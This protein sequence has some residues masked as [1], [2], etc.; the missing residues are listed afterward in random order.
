MTE[1]DQKS[2][3]STF[4]SAKSIFITG[5]TGFIGKQIIEKLLRSCSGLDRIYV[6]VR[7]KHGIHVDQRI[8]QLCLLPLFDEVRLLIPN[9]KSKL[10][11][12]IGDITKN[13]FD[14][15]NED[16]QLIIENCQIVINS[17][18]SVRFTEP[19][20]QAIKS[21]LYSVRNMINLCKKMQQLQGWVDNYSGATNIIVVI[22]KGLMRV[23]KSRPIVDHPMIPVDTVANMTL[24]IAW[25]TAINHNSYS[26]EINPILHLFL[27][28]FLSS[29]KPTV[30]NCCTST[31]N[32][33]CLSLQDF[34]NTIVKEEK[35]IGFDNYS[36]IGPSVVA[37][38]NRPHFYFLRF[39]GE[40]LPAYFIDLIACLTFR[41]AKM[42]KLGRKVITLKS[43]LE[44]FSRNQWIFVNRNSQFLQNQMNDKDRQVTDDNNINLF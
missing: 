32:K 21:N 36:L 34:L 30:Y 18:A 13:E 23:S 11:P 6:L 15:S 44:Y 38:M 19:L 42:V 10:I 25:F 9:F 35:T 41:K 22:G 24:A 31:F 14:L 3:I 17:G 20:K 37:T 12:I 26:L 39:F 33:T 5:G 29:S 4:F 16:Q 27:I 28:L 7:P 1:N 40:I 2:A 43:A 8:E